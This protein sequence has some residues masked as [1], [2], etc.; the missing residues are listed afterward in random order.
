LSLSLVLR[1]ESAPRGPFRVR[2]TSLLVT[3][4]AF[5]GLALVTS[6]APAAAV[7][8][9]GVYGY[10]GPSYSGSSH[11]PTQ[12][13]T[14]SK[15]WYQDGSWWGAMFSPN[16]GWEIKRWDR[17]TDTWVGTGTV[18]DTRTNILVDTLWVGGKLYVAAH[19]ATD[20]TNENPVQSQ[21][22]RPARLYRFSYASSTY[23]LDDGF[24]TAISDFSTDAMTIDRDSQGRIWAAWTQVS[25]P[26][27]TWQST[28]Y[29]NVSSVDGTSWGSPFVLPVTNPTATADDIAA[30][31]A[32]QGKIGVMWSN[33]SAGT[34]VFAT[35]S[36]TD[37]PDSGWSTSNALVGTG[38]ADDHLN[39]KSVQY[40][41][42]G[43]VV[44]VSKTS[45][46]DISSDKTNPQLVLHVYKTSTQT[47]TT[48][49]VAQVGD[50]VSR[51]QVLVDAEQARVYVAYT[52]TS[53]TVTGCPFS[54]TS[55]SI[56]MKSS[57]LDNP[58]FPTGRGQL[59]MEDPSSATLNDVTAT[60]Q[61]V[62]AATGLLWMA[63]L[64][65]A[66][67][68]W[69]ADLPQPGPPPVA[70]FTASTQ[71]GAAPLPVTFTDTSTNSPTSWAWNF[72]DG[73]TSA[74]PSPTHTY[75]NPGTYLVSLTVGKD[76][77]TST[78]T[79]TSTIT[80]TEAPPQVGQV[81]FS[82]STTASLSSGTS[83]TLNTVP[84]LQAGDLLVASVV[85]RGTPSITA[86]GGWTQVRNTVLGTT[87]RMATFAYRLTTNGGP[88]D[89]TYII[90]K[91]Q[92]ASATLLAYRGADP[93][94]PI[95]TSAEATSAVSSTDL[96]AP[97][98]TATTGQQL[99]TIVS[100]SNLTTIT[101][102][103]GMTER[104]ESA[105]PSTA[106]YKASIEVAD[107]LLTASGNTGTRTAR[108]ASASTTLAQTL[109][110]A[111]APVI[112]PQ[113]P[114]A[115][116]TVSATT[117]TAPFTVSF[118][119]TSTNSPTSWLWDFGDGTTSNVASPSHTYA[120]P[121]TYSVSL[122]VTNAQGSS[123]T[124][125]TVTATAAASGVTFV[126]A[127]T[128]SGD[129][130]TSVVVPTPQGIASG[131]L[132]LASLLVRG[133]PTVT[134]P[135]GWSVV[136]N[137][138]MSTTARLVT[139]SK[140]A[141]ASEPA[142]TTF[143]LSA[144]QAFTATIAAYRNATVATSGAATSTTATT[145]IVAPSVTASGPGILVTVSGIAVLAGITPDPSLAERSEVATS[146][147]AKYKATLETADGAV[148]AAG[149]TGTRTAT[150]TKS[151]PTLAHSIALVPV[152]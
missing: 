120:V 149:D 127:T 42:N 51:P 2:L 50:C 27:G 152:S 75:A 111:P 108:A 61:P 126:D 137:T 80:V 36:D 59:I 83:I 114:V 57:M 96:I 62:N 30:L 18:F 131:D 94:T 87:S 104:A 45:L 23:T 84:G 65:G 122:T 55:G 69:T 125:S 98:V 136:Q 13:K 130:G 110:I 124:S 99:V 139:F 148:T 12:A 8:G 113:P 26:S 19:V 121:G 81:A 11:P 74:E 123:S 40:G 29:V 46:N 90:S 117:G 25:N 72:G 28:V 66:S 118:T 6:Q 112:T 70:S 140:V 146:S 39:L 10:Q 78:S 44:A 128:A 3:V 134:A 5:S 86:P 16:L 101:P 53:S 132:L 142:W 102:P 88:A 141:T 150:S 79:S 143:G 133:A 49:P 14:Q 24:P 35:H 71:T 47:F 135:V 103:G 144:A 85:A 63:S 116:F 115:S 48:V 43:Y 21:S 41:E 82:G 73:V 97:A 60:K 33:E 31:I 93:T 38:M 4:L 119:D 92:P 145:V 17:G 109:A 64:R 107:Q 89:W 15:L 151:G 129:S 52:A 34:I 56:W 68:Y 106:K 54:G 91:A 1:Q 76:A 147:T 100:T 105:T 22:G 32:F 77:S 20:S 7:G 67:D 58:S 9:T 138:P 37:S 95:V